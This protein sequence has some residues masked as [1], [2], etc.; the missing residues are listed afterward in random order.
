MG[1]DELH[2]IYLGQEIVGKFPRI[3]VLSGWDAVS[4]LQDLSLL[5]E[6]GPG[7]IAEDLVQRGLAV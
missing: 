5:E 1:G 7:D 3:Y 4:G 2:R 6:I